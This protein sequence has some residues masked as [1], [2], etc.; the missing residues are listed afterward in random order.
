M[1]VTTILFISLAAILALGIAFFQYLYKS[2]KTASKKYIFFGLRF[3]SVFLLLLLIINPKFTSTEILTERPGLILAVDNSASITH[4]EQEENL[5]AFI[6]QIKNNPEIR[7]GFDLTT[8]TF[9]RGIDQNDSLSFKESQT[10]INAALD[11]IKDIFRGKEHALILLTDGNQT[12]GREYKYFQS[13]ENLT[14]IPTVVGDTTQY[15]DV[16]LERLNV[17]RYAFLNNRFPVE[18]IVNYTGNQAVETSFEIRS[19][20]TVMYSETINFDAENTSKIIETTLPAGR[21][22]VLSYKAVISPLESEKNTQNNQRK[23]A[24]EVVDERTNVLLLTSMVHPDLG[25]LKKAVE[26]NQQRNLDIKNLEED[27]VNIK[28]YQLVILYQPNNAFRKVLEELKAEKISRLLITGT[29]TNWNFLNAAQDFFSKDFTSQHQ[30]ISA[31]INPNFGRF[32]FEDMGFGGLPPLEDYFGNL[33]VSGM[34][35]LLFQEI[36]GVET[37]QPL[38]AIAD[39]SDEKFGVL[40]GENIWRWRAAVFRENGSFEPFDDFLGKIIQNL[41]SRQ[42]RERLSVDYESF[43]Y[44]NE[45]VRINAQFFDE[46]YQFD[47]GGNLLISITHAETGEKTEAALRHQNNTYSIVLENLAEGAY[48][49]ELTEDTSGISRAGSFTVIAS[50]VEARFSSANFEDLQTLAENNEQK[51]YF[52]DQPDDL[53]SRLLQDEQFRP[54]QKSRQ[55][56]LPLIDWYYLLFLLVLLLAAEWFYRKY[57]GLI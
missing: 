41:S 32:Q 22:G 17:N 48:S 9:G 21:L 51:V 40:F 26:G 4:L 5:Q 24:V 11:E 47:P 42:Q 6:D 20:E 2:G 34:D 8:L 30:E 55:K 27:N 16:K 29:K 19:G 50:D 56:K 25:V 3:F 49:F 45:T 1:N 57:L 54:V 10:D 39:N 46:N 52:A 31:V 43:Y 18:A 13:N 53:V 28:D 23:F 12:L 35:A 44:G 38:L 14:I 15:P 36:E 7:K 37:R 33:E